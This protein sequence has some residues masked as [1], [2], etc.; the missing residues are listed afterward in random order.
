MNQ[1]GGGGSLSNSFS[2]P[3]VDPFLIMISEW[4][5]R[6]CVDCNE[7]DKVDT[8]SLHEPALDYAD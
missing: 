4:E 1:N 8:T 3:M 6:V 7:Y 2:G 5:W